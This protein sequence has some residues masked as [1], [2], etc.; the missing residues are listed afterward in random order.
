M[1]SHG[2]AYHMLDLYCR[3]I[4]DSTIFCRHCVF[5]HPYLRDLGM[6]AMI[7]LVC[8]CVCQKI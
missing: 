7:L 8:A 4:N 5:M 1:C 2:A 3:M 6:L